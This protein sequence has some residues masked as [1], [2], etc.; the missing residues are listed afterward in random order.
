MVRDQGES[1]ADLL[2]SAS[3]FDQGVGAVLFA[4]EAES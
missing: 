2:G 4:G 1:E 3:L